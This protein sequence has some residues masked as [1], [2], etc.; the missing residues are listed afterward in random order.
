MPRKTEAER[1]VDE[2]G[3]IGER[4]ADLRSRQNEIREDLLFELSGARP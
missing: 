3:R 2:Y 4:I 1:L